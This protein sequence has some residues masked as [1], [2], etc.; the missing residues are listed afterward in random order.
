MW[1]VLRRL[2]NVFT[3]DEIKK[4]DFSPDVVLALA[5]SGTF[6][7]QFF[8]IASQDPEALTN[9]GIASLTLREGGL[10]GLVPGLVRPLRDVTRLS[11]QLVL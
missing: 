7:E 11:A 8:E 4:G 2:I 3:R 5:P 1:N 9:V 6:K 10:G